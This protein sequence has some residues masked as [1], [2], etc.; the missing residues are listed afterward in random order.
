VNGWL[1]ALLVVAACVG[2]YHQAAIARFYRS[3]LRARRVP[4]R[5][6]VIR[7]RG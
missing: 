5:G 1:W 2:A 6:V 4:F 7:F 3:R